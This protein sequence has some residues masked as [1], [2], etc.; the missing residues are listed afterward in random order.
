[1]AKILRI[2]SAVRLY[3]KKDE[4][5]DLKSQPSIKLFRFRRSREI[6]HQ[7]QKKIYFEMANPRQ[8]VDL[9]NLIIDYQ[10]TSLVCLSRRAK[11]KVGLVLGNDIRAVFRGYSWEFFGGYPVPA[12]LDTGYTPK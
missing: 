1:M 4:Y 9:I 11:G 8:L 6:Y 12:C 7:Y 10:E 3:F 2:R 5:L